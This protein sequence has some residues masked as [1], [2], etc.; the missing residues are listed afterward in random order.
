VAVPEMVDVGEMD[1]VRADDTVPATCPPLKVGVEESEMVEEEVE[2]PPPR[3]LPPPLEGLVE[4]ENGGEAL[5]VKEGLPDELGSREGVARGDMVALDESVE[6]T[7]RLGVSVGVNTPEVLLKGVGE[8]ENVTDAVPVE[9]CIGGEGVA[10]MQGDAL[11]VTPNDTLPPPPGPPSTPPAKVVGE[12]EVEVV[13]EELPP[14]PPGLGRDAVGEGDSVFQAPLGVDDPPEP[15]SDALEDGVNVG[16]KGEGEGREE[17]VGR[18]GEGEGEKV[19]SPLELLTVGVAERDLKAVPVPTPA[20]P[21]EGEEVGVGERVG[22]TRD[23]LVKE[24]R[25]GSIGE[26]EMSGVEDPVAPSLEA[27][28]M[29]DEERV[30]PSALGVINALPVG[31]RGVRVG[32]E[33]LLGSRGDTV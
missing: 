27:L 25:V 29:G 5:G 10:V 18:G 14:P 26:A 33:V 28:G 11:R 9:R 12:E 19:P 7:A 2:D 32:G 13:G 23:G 3:P 15:T 30:G 22:G 24:D 21:V 4:G 1:P 20:A 17:A 16:S 31:G 6:R 8:A